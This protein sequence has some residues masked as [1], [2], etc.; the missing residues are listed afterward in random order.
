MRP[1]TELNNSTDPYEILGVEPGSP[2]AIIKKAWRILV[3]RY[4]PD[5]RGVTAGATEAF[6]RIQTAYETLT[7]PQQKE[8]Y[9]QK[10]W[11]FQVTREKQLASPHDT[12]SFLQACI[13]LT[14]RVQHQNEFRLDTDYLLHYLLFLLSPQHVALFKDEKELDITEE[15][16][17]LLLLCVQPL[18]IKQ[19]QV[20]LSQLVKLPG[21]ISTRLV[22]EYKTKMKWQWQLERYRIPLVAAMVLLLCGLIVYLAR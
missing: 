14:Q 18:P 21:N 16:T 11:L 7:D 19:Q 4:H 3:Q 22:A 20:V 1:S 2:P 12:R 8:K 5:K 13:Q 10:R 9:L 17:H 6:Q 15:S